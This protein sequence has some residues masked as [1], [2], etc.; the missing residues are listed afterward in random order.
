M[1]MP[2]LFFKVFFFLFK[3]IVSLPFEARP[4]SIGGQDYNKNMVTLPYSI[5]TRIDT[6]RSNFGCCLSTPF[7]IFSS[8]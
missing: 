4:G 6:E 1:Q 8:V 3:F 7:N 2:S 5:Q